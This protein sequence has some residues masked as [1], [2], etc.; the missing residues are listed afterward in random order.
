MTAQGEAWEETR[1]LEI[2]RKG[3]LAIRNIVRILHISLTCCAV[4]EA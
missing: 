4:K 3:A 1:K 2:H